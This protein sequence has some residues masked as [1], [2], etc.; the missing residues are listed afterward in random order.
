MVKKANGEINWI[1]GNFVKPIIDLT[2]PDAC[3]WL[4]SIIKQ[5]MLGI[6]LSDGCAILGN[7]LDPDCRLAWGKYPAFFITSIP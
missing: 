7:K 5:N 2:N 4:K 6:G 1:K 3:T